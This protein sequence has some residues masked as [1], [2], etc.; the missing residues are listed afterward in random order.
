MSIPIDN[1]IIFLLY[2]F[3]LLESSHVIPQRV[4]NIVSFNLAN[5]IQH[6]DEHHEEHA[7]HT[8]SD[9]APWEYIIKVVH[10]FHGHHHFINEPGEKSRYGKS[11]KQRPHAIKDTLEIHHFLEIAVRHSHRAEHGKLSPAQFNIRGN[12]VKH[13]GNRNQ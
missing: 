9:A 5:G 11:E 4:N 8:N 10:L 7:K 6:C 3:Y 12:R 13:I 1:Y 2:D